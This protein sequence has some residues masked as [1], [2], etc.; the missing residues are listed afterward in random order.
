[1]SALPL[2]PSVH[3]PMGAARR[4]RRAP[5]SWPMRAHRACGMLHG[6]TIN[7]S[8]SGMLFALE[9]A[10]HEQEFCILS[11]DT[12]GSFEPLELSGRVVRELSHHDARAPSALVYALCLHGH[13][14]SMQR[15]WESSLFA[16]LSRQG[17]RG[18]LHLPSPSSSALSMIQRAM[19]EHKPLWLA[20]GR[21]APLNLP[22]NLILHPPEARCRLEL[23][24]I[25]RHN[26]GG[27]TLLEIEQRDQCKH[28]AVARLGEAVALATEPS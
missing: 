19:T 18:A 16:L 20:L 13:A 26:Q 12:P 1:M 28:E 11:V 5:A 4:A 14:P 9:S 21:P 15:R 10:L 3:E 25:A 6:E 24:V 23:G 17:A 22:F 7:V 8:R 2:E 27:R